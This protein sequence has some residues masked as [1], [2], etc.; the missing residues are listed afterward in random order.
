MPLLAALGVAGAVAVFV[1]AVIWWPLAM[2]PSVGDVTELERFQ[3]V[4]AARGTLTQLF[5]GLAI[6]IVGGATAWLTLRRVSA[7]EE[8]VELARKGQVTER[9]TRAIEQLGASNDDGSPRVEIRAGGIR[10]LERIATESEP[11]FWPIVD[12]LAAYLREHATPSQADVPGMSTAAAIA[13]LG[14][15]WPRESTD[16]ELDLRGT[17]VP[18]MNLQG[19]HLVR[20]NLSRADLSGADLRGADLTR[21][22]L[23]GADLSRADLRDATLSNT[24]LVNANLSGAHLEGANLINANLNGARL[25]NA[26]LDLARLNNATLRSADL[27]GVRFDGANLRGAFLTAAR[28]QGSHLSNANLINATLDRANLTETRYT[29]DTAWPRGFEPPE[30]AILIGD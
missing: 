23:G 25:S 13:A 12:I 7:L 16:R 22:D 2:A 21:A 28:L 20:A 11:D 26:H 30:S 6:V 27:R 15:L 29:A 18:G 3:S 5:G 8:Q 9:F 14:R 24:D 10:S 1:A 4:N 17:S 19:S